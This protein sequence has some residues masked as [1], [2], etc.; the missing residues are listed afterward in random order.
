MSSKN[1]IWVEDYRPKT[2]EECILP[3]RIKNVLR[4]MVKEKNIQ[5]Y[6]AVGL[7]GSGKTSSAR[8]LCEELGIEYLII[9]MSKESGI[10][11]VRNKIVSY[12]SSLSFTSDYKVIILDEFDYANKNSAQPALRGIIE[13]FAENCRFIITA[14]YHNKIMDALF[15]RCPPIHFE[16]TNEERAS[17]LLQYIK[18]VE[19]ILNENE[20][21]FDRVEVA[22]Y[23][24]NQ[25]PDFRK[26]LKT[27][28]LSSK[29]GE[30]QLTSLGSN[31]TQKINELIGY[32][33]DENFAGCREW[34]VNNVQG[35]DGHLVR[36]ALYDNL[37][38]F[39]SD[40]SIP[41]AILLINKYDFQESNVVDK[42]INMAAFIIELMITLDFK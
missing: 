18:R 38:S 14:N 41:E 9:N 40:S 22:K 34:V 17:C 29:D 11:T 7:P 16:F 6:S 5:N 13:E 39:V 35:N 8:A 1:L 10:D 15:S 2:V 37:K 42:E 28:Q 4:N 33:K 26:T 3:D 19:N 20:V 25:Y 12:A 30:L 36:R 32:L 21:S 24:K 27:L 23:C 31:S